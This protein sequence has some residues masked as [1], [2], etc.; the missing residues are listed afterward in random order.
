MREPLVHFLALGALLFLI[1]AIARGDVDRTDE[2]L[3]GPGDVEQLV[4]GFRRTWQRPPTQAELQGLVEERIKEEVFFREALAMGLDQEDA[5]I[6]R[7]LRQKLEFLTEDLA[8]QA[9]PTEAELQE[10]LDGHSDAFRSDDRLTFSQIYLS[11]DRRGAEGARQEAERLLEELAGVQRDVDTSAL[12]DPLMLG[13]RFEAISE[14][15]VGRLFGD[16][17]AAALKDVEPGAWTGP[18]ESGFGLHLVF[19]ADREEG[20]VPPLAEIAAAVRREV[21]AERREQVNEQ[22]YRRMLERY[23]VT[24]EWP[25]W[26]GPDSSGVAR[27]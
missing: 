1:G 8:M 17:L 11:T 20:R 18:L 2:I 23:S 22:I 25:E 21:L 13:H 15:E 24:V 19:V 3:V 16:R 27:R 26:T 14:R 7:R 4:E 9:E 10:Y 5:I 6:R 12:G